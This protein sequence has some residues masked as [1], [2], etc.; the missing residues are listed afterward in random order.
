MTA[1][2][3]PGVPADLAEVVERHGHAVAAGDN[4]TVLA[5]FRPDRVG[6]LLASARPPEG[7][8]SAEL[9]DIEPGPDG[10]FSAFIRYTGTGGE[11][12][13]RSR[14]IQL[15]GTWLVTQVRNVPDTPPR[16]SMAHPS[17]DGLDAPHWEG[18]RRGE[19]RMQHCPHCD[20]WT[21]SPRPICP[22]CHASDL[23]WPVVDPVGRIYSW[24]RTWQ[25]FS[26]EV[27]GHLPYVVVV[28]ELPGAGSRRLLGVL[29]DGDGADVRIGA[30]VKGEIEPA[31]DPEGY[32]L[33]RWRLV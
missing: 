17:D 29:L 2:E 3:F 15:D 18:L 12:V 6:Q 14:W 22:G 25:P 11:A 30:E 24:T 32:P 7:M 27:T 16:T 8:H 1:K 28:V 19:L 10:L 33:L 23:E 26:P 13:F 9:L 5:D 4:A 21:W 20:R 31:A